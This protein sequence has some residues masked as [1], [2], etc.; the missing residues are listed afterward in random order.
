M[1]AQGRSMGSCPFL[2]DRVDVWDVE[3]EVESIVGDVHWGVGYRSEKFG[4]V[5]LDDSYVRFVGPSPDIYIKPKL[6]TRTLRSF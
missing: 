3:V 1:R 2:E 6:Y 4:L 5:S